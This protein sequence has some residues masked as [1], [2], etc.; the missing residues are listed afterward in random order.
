MNIPL[1]RWLLALSLAL[2]VSLAAFRARLLSPG[3]AAA[4]LVVGT[5]VFGGA[6][7]PGAALLLA[8]FV[9]SSLLTRAINPRA[10]LAADKFSKGGRRD[11]SQVL[12]NG[13]LA[14]LLAGVI[15]PAAGVLSPVVW[16]AY[17]GALAAANADTWA[18]EIGVRFGRRP[19]LITTRAPATPGTSG[20]VTGAG[21]AA[22]FGGAGL[23]AALSLLGAPGARAPL[24]LAGL[25]A[26][27]GSLGALAD[28][29]LGATLQARYRC[30]AC[31]KV[32]EQHPQ[33]RCGGSTTLTGGWAVVS[34]EVVNFA[35]TAVGAALAGAVAGWLA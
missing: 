18:T 35:C 23:I 19:V 4:A 17:A 6:G 5:M 34:N 7:L 28:S 16:A 2:I 14:A 12:A 22:S 20:A 32:T 11:A 9:S 3:G 30:L 10:A 21:L 15:L 29:L 27:A 1:S 13:G 33:H 24:L 25:T 8:F 31:G 26:F